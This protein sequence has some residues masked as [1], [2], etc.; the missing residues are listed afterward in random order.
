MGIIRGAD[1][2]SIKSAAFGA[3]QGPQSEAQ[4]VV[5]QQVDRK[6]TP[7]APAPAP[8]PAQVA[9]PPPPPVFDVPGDVLQSFYDQAIAQGLED[10]K[11]Q[12]FSELSVLQARYTAAV[13]QLGALSRELAAHNQ[14]QI[15]V[16]ACKLAEKIVRHTVQANPTVL[17]KMLDEEL[18]KLEGVD[19]ATIVCSGPDFD[20][21]AE[22]APKL[23]EGVGGVF[24]LRVAPD[25]EL[26][27]G[28][29]RIET[30]IGSVDGVVP[31]RIAELEAN[32]GVDDV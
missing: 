31:S 1:A 22:N 8:A 14:R 26:E 29:F 18:R 24:K 15:L 5:F 32:L 10:G 4:A 21:I 11:A 23:A 3:T 27:Y 6:G 12:V 16:V 13:E 28:D 19:E 7:V 30:R 17:Y 2:R 20:F 25:P 9:A